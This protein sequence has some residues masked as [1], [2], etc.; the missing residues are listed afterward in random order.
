M[1]FLFATSGG[2]QVT[3]I[4]GSETIGGASGIYTGTMSISGNNWSFK[5]R[6]SG[7]R[8]TYNFDIRAQDGLTP[9]NAANAVAQVGGLNCAIVTLGACQPTDYDIVIYGS[10]DATISGKF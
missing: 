3:S 1:A 2:L 5:G 7:I 8:D 9:R 10:V 6:V 4:R